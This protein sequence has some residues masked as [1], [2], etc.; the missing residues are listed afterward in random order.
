MPLYEYLCQQCSKQF[1][2]LAG[3]ISDNAEARCP[4]CGSADLKKLMS[5]V[6]RGRSDDDRMEAMAEKLE[7]RDLDDPRDLR[8]F[9]REMGREMS[10]ETGEDM[11]DEMEELIEAEARGELDESGGGAG[12][13]SGDDGTI[14]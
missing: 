11:G 7:T 5:R 12:G 10:A 3:V 13:G 9:A 6:T 14:Y 1:T 2:F 8:R 4:R